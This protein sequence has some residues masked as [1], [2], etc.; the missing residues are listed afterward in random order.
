MKKGTSIARDDFERGIRRV[1]KLFIHKGVRCGAS[2]WWKDVNAIF[3]VLKNIFWAA[4]TLVYE[5]NIASLCCYND[6]RRACVCAN[7]CAQASQTPPQ[8]S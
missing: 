7:Y 3:Y 2:C 1:E 8:A 5:K 6:S 4:S